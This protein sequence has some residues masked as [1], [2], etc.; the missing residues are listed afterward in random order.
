MRN[1]QRLRPFRPTLL[2]S[3][4]AA[5]GGLKRFNEIK[6]IEL[7]WNFSGWLLAVKGY[8]EHYQPMITIDTKKQQSL[9]RNLGGAP[10]DKLVFTPDRTWIERSD[11]S[12]SMERTDPRGSFDGHTRTTP[13][14]DLHLTYFVGYA[15]WNY[16]TTPF[17]FTWPGVTTREIETHEERGQL[18]RVL[19]VTYP[20]SFA[21]HTKVQKFFFDDNFM[22]QREDYVTDVAGGI[23]AHYCFDHTDIGG[24]VFPMMR[25]VTRRDAETS[26]PVLGGPTSFLLDYC[27]IKLIEESG[28][29]VVNH[30]AYSSVGPN[31]ISQ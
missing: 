23:V 12:V 13:W 7:K 21:T 26:M 3:I 14:N 19:E 30:G 15:F 9:I 29:V 28:G 24:L 10:D 4:L 27:S 2:E 17:C 18:W 1:V 11:G 22:L 25:R 6:S 31:N 5:H 16:L 20:D 8:P